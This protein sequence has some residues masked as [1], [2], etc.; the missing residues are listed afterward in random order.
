MS[1]S[2]NEK[3]SP[4]SPE[5]YR[6]SLGMRLLGHAE[7]QTQP[8]APHTTREEFEAM[9]RRA[10]ESTAALSNAIDGIVPDDNPREH[11]AERFDPK[12]G[13]PAAGPHAH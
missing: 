3:R 12:L 4:P 2:R 9:T 13:P 5:G 11:A 6:H 1:A 10:V 8:I 7:T